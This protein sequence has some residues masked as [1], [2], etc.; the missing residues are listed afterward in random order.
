MAE[1][2]PKH[3]ARFDAS[4][5]VLPIP[6]DAPPEIPRIT[7]QSA[8]HEWECQVSPARADI[9]WRRLRDDAAP[10]SLRDL[11]AL[12][13]DVLLSYMS[14]QGARVGRAAGIVTRLAEHETPGLFL[15]RHF[16]KERWDK[17]PL[18][19]PENFELHA[20]KTFELAREFRVNSWARSKTAM[21][22]TGSVHKPVVLF[23]QD[24]NTLAAE[25]PGEPMLQA[26]AITRFFQ[27]VA[28]E[29]DVILKLYFPADE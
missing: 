5:T 8:N 20:H 2:Y 4:P 22:A 17:A 9:I 19:R 29:V 18:N 23:E 21:M 11:F 16:C 27:A 12:A 14:S 25:S 28:T 7:L 15:A 6:E 3:A 10:H 26:E 24:L 13:G 1:F